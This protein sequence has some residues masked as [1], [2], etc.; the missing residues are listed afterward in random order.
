[1]VEAIVTTSS[2]VGPSFYPAIISAI[3]AIICAFIS[4]GNRKKITDNHDETTDKVDQIHVLV[5][6]RLEEALDKIA[7]LESVARDRIKE[8]DALGKTVERL[9]NTNAKMGNDDDGGH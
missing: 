7:T 9:K 6:R 1:M 3:A 5:N 4:V 2:T 8:L